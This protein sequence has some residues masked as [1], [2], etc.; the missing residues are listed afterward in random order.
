M[1][2]I[3]LRQVTKVYDGRSALSNVSITFAPGEHTAIIGPSGSGKTTLLGL[4]GRL[5]DAQQG[6]LRLDGVPI[7]S[8]TLET[9][10]GALGYVPQDSFLFSEPYHENIRFGADEELNDLEVAEL[11]ER[12]AM[13]EEVLRFPSGADTVIGERGV[14]LSGGQRQRTCIARALARNPR[15]LILDDCLSAVDTETERELLGN[16]RTAGEGRTVIVAAHRLSTVAE[17][18]QIL[19]LTQEGRVEDLGT[20]S[21]LLERDGW[22]RTT[23]EQQQRRRELEVES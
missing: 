7:R 16:L 23:W 4:L 21:E 8:L 12:A 19:I 22:Y 15:I 1:E 17:A 5:Y 3:E 9:L 14:T 13:T 18:D 6:T 11:I 20:H 10:R 2:A